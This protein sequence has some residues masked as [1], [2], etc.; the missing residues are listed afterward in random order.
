MKITINKPIEYEAK[1]L[2]VDAGVRYWDDAK[3]NGEYDTNCEDSE[4]PGVPPTIP[5]A[6]YIGEQNRVL[7]G[8]DWRWR[9]LIDIETGQIV[10]WRQGTTANI[11]YKVCDDFACEILDPKKDVI[12]SY[13]GYVPKVMC[14]ADDGYGDYIIMNIDENGFIQRWNKEFVK[15]LVEQADDN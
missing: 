5:C 15:S 12:A 9:P 8:G 6:E 4:N 2:K 3:V 11:H 14:P 7:N 1:Y 10:N 13:D